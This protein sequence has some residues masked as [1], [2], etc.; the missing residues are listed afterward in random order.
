MT[1]GVCFFRS[2]SQHDQHHRGTGNSGFYNGLSF[3]R[4]VPGFVIQAGANNTKTAHRS[5]TN[6]I[7]H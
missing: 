2:G 1:I 4:I 5:M 7:Q 6:S 3:Y